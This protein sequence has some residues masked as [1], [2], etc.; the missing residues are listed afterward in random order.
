MFWIEIRSNRC[1]ETSE[2]LDYI[3]QEDP[4][5]DD[6]EGYFGNK[7]DMIMGPQ[8]YTL[9][10][11]VVKS[12]PTKW[13]EESLREAERQIRRYQDRVKVLTKEL[14]KAE[15]KSINKVVD[16]ILKSGEK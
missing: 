9:T 5:I 11:K 16:Q 10:Q 13:L 2:A 6:L 3:P 14:D 4:Q 15:I 12:P 7:F 8:E 1:R